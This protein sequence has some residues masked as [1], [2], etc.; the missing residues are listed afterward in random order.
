MSRNQKYEQSRRASGLR[1]LTVWVPES[2]AAEFLLA[3]ARCCEDR[4]WRV[5]GLRSS[6]TGRVASVERASRIVPA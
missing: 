2:H 1:K 5:A 6:K 4:Q 3:A